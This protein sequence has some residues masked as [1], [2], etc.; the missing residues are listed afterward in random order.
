MSVPAECR[1]QIEAAYRAMAREARYRP[2]APSDGLGNITAQESELDLDAEVQSYAEE[3]WGQEDDGT[4]LIGCANYPERPAMIY[5]VEAARLCCGEFGSR[6]YALRLL[7]MA[8]RELR[9]EKLA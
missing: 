6:R 3:W 5:A 8:A 7:E 4:Y 2:C 1:T 9:T